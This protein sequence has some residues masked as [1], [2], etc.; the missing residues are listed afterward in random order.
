MTIELACKEAVFHF[1]KKSIDDATVPAWCVKAKG[2]TYYVNHVESSLPWSTKETPGNEHT[3][4]SIK[5]RECYL[6]IDDDNTATFAPLTAEIKDRLENPPKSVRVVTTEGKKLRVTLTHNE[7]PH[8]LIRNL[9]SACGRF[10]YSITDIR[11]EVDLL[12]LKMSIN[13]IRILQPN[14]TYYKIYDKSV[15]ASDKL[16][17][18]VDI[19]DD[20]EDYEDEDYEDEEI[21]TDSY[22][23]LYQN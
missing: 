15:A 1:N 8:G 9:G 6:T 4:G 12:M 10:V 14:E 21:D 13:D 17:A 18:Y 2:Q 11:S 22:E 7:I 20:D 23:D 19:D 3:K 16:D 5:F